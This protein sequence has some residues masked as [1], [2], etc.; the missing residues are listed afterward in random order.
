LCEDSKGPKVHLS[1]LISVTVRPDVQ[2]A[3]GAKVSLND[4]ALLKKWI[5]VN[6]DV[7]VKY[8]DPEI[9]YAEDAIASLEPIR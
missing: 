2:V 8:W 1:E 4:L 7:I 6:R 3:G 5:E 9:E